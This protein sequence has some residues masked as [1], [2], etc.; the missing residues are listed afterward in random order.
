MY[1]CTLLYWPDGLYVLLCRV[2]CRDT[3]PWCA[4]HQTIRM[5][6]TYIGTR[7]S[8]LVSI[9]ASMQYTIAALKLHSSYAGI[10]RREKKKNNSASCIFYRDFVCNIIPAYNAKPVYVCQGS[11]SCSYFRTYHPIDT[12][13]CSV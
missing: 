10:P 12:L 4:Q 2:Y 7:T 13:Q 5:L 6:H 3:T 8:Q 9:R 1:I 11:R